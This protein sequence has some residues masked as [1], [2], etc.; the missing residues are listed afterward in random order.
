MSKFKYEG[1]TAEDVKTRATMSGGDFDSYLSDKV[2]FLKVKEGETTIRIMPPTWDTKSKWGNN[3]GIEVF[4]HRDIGPDKG[5]YLC[6]EKMLGEPCPICEA[7]ARIDDDD[8]LVKALKPGRQTLAYVIDRDNEKEG[9]LVWRVGIKGEKEIQSRSSDKKTGAVILIDDPEE[10]FDISF[11]RDGAGLKTTYT[12]W[13]VAR[14]ATPLCEKESRQDAWLEFIEDNP[15]P[16]LLII[17][18]Y[19]Y[20]DAIYRGKRSSKSDKADSEAR[21]ERPSRSSRSSRDEG[22]KDDRRSS[23]GGRDEPA[24]EEDRRGR[25]RDRDE[26]DEPRSRSRRDEPDDELPDDKQMKENGDRDR[27]RR[28]EPD[29]KDEPRSRSRDRDRDDR[30]EKDE[31]RSRSRRDEPEPEPESRR[32]RGRDEPEEGKG[33]DRA[34][35]SLERLQPTKKR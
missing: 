31:P 7:R 15:L 12:G 21:D 5:A 11:R 13:D 8:D 33:T 10:G 35:K 16:D 3:W 32:S 14:D 22:E 34:K 23:R 25:G 20:L 4:V 24:E 6:P 28:E 30:D 18:E 19:D 17:H 9:P 2:R 1:R 26:K 27:R 29:E